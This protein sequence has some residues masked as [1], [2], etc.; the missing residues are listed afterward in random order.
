MKTLIYGGL[1]MLMIL[2]PVN[3]SASSDVAKIETAIQSV[4]TLAD[5]HEF[6]ALEKLFAPEVKVDYTSAFGG[7]AELKSPQ[8]LM[9]A[10][11]GLLPGFDA[12]RHNLS[13][14][15]AEVKGRNASATAD[16]VADHY[17]AGKQ[18]QIS[19]SYQY[20]LIDDDGNWLITE[21]VFLAGAEIGSRDVL[22]LATEAAKADPVSYI[23]RQQT[24]QVVRD[25]LTSLEEKDMQKFANVWADD[26]VQDMPYSPEGFPKR[27]EG[28]ANLIKHYGAWPEI[29]GKANFTKA[30]I[31]HSMQDPELVYVEY[32]GE[33]DVL[34]T[35]RVYKQT[36]G[37]LF[38]V[39]NGKIKLFR[40][41]YDPAAFAYAFDLAGSN[42]FG[43]QK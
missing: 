25:F 36:Y 37:G 31:M 11:A 7:E 3:A 1:A 38:H 4:A 19:G 22:G 21:M 17:I 9:T 43:N 40:E 13:N 32:K 35:G 39:E 14:I 30:L 5:G 42:N 34:P 6:E 23:K 18:W 29:S 27:V 10:W 33:V 16:V 2:S 15:K 41:Y 8:A 20:R 28:K 12:T 24:K 26:A